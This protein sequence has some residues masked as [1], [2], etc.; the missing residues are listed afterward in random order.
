MYTAMAFAALTVGLTS[1]KVS[2]N[3]TWLNDYKVAQLRVTEAGKPMVV[4]VGSGAEGWASVVRDGTPGQVVTK[5]LT[6]K[7]VCVYA[8]TNTSAG[9]ALAGA[10]DISGQGLVISDKS[11][12]YQAYS[13]TG[14][15]T[16]SELIKALETYA[17]AKE[18][19]RTETVG[20]ELAFGCKGGRGFGGGYATSSC[21]AAAPQYV[22]APVGPVAPAPVPPPLM[23]VPP[24]MAP[25]PVAYAGGC[26]GGYARGWGGGWGGKFGGCGGGGCGGSKC[27]HGGGWS[28]WGGGGCGGGFRSGCGGGSGGGFGGGGCCK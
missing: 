3:P 10:L 21:G 17:D 9:R 12:N 16:K 25:A 19:T 24:P 23:M 6:D 27:G 11:G 22:A 18:V 26:G 5:L 15:L 4:V 2:P 20:T 13:R 14:D 8:D 7:F 28:G 1:G